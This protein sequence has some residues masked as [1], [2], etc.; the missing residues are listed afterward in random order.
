MELADRSSEV[1]SRSGNGTAKDEMTPRDSQTQM[2][3]LNGHGSKSQELKLGNEEPDDQSPIEEV[4]LTV[5]TTD[6]PSIPVWTFRM[7]TLGMLSC[8]LLAFLNQFFSYRTEP[9]TISAV[10]AQIACL[11][12]GRLMAATLPTR[13]W[14]RGTPLEFT[15]NPGPFNM[16]E[17]VLITIF[18]NAGAGGAYAIGI[19]TIVKAL[20]KKPM[21]FF[22]GLAITVTTQMIGYGWA[23]LFRN[24]LVKPAHM[25]W[26]S[27]LVQVSLFRTLHERDVRPKGGLTR[28]QFFVMIL[29]ISFCWYVMPGY[30]FPM[31]SSLSWV[32]WAWPKSVLAQ[33]LGSGLRGLGLGAVALDWSTVASYLGSPLATPFFAIANIFLGFCI[34]T[35]IITPICYYL[36]V[37]NAKTFPIFSSRLFDGSGHRYDINKVIDSQFSLD[38]DAYN[39]YSKLHISTFF[40][41]TYGVGFAALT[42][43]VSHVFL[44]HGRDIWNQMRAALRKDQEDVHT[45]LMKSY[46]EVPQWWFHGL[47]V[48]FIILS[49]AA[50]EVYNDQLQLPWWGVLF[51]CGLAMFFTLPIGVIAAT[52]NQVPG[53]NIITEYLIGYAYPGKPVANVCFKTYGYISMT[54]AVSFLSDFKLGHYMKIPPR[55]MFVVQLFGTVVAAVVNLGTA[56]WLLTTV[57][58]IC[59]LELLPENSPWTCPSDR[60]FFDASVIWGLIGPQRIFG[61]LGLYGKINWFFLFGALAPVPVWLAAWKWPEK[62]WI[63]YINMPI[64]IGATGIMPPA[65]PVNFTSWFVVGFIFNYVIFKHRKGWWKRY[66]YVMSAA[67]DAGLAFMGVLLYFALQLEDKS[68]NWWGVNLDNCP[69]A[70][71]PTASG[72][73]VNGCPV[74]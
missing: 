62:A 36:D 20:Y 66:N 17:H 48:L 19:V 34:I 56:W 70:A 26:P 4:A 3:E 6:D 74:P 71:C 29:G 73:V 53:L 21:T 61:N 47:L 12:L 8:V 25:W 5:A 2:N 18:A 63:R 64:L 51:A 39:N 32:C 38:V 50:C 16:K 55:S 68:I 23:G 59:D 31:L 42:S 43:T 65:T 44:F 69:L 67:L 10:S 35:Y 72:V 15:M 46:P 22:V 37:Y 49:V 27:N 58:N 1:R 41:F 13:K 57:E 54:Q 45:R 40:V 24:F 33:Q 7:W 9:L 14:F 11:P 60:V 28:S 30:L 52:T